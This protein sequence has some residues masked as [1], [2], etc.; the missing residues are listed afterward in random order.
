MDN[1]FSIKDKVIVITGAG[2]V[3]CSTM[4]VSLAQAGAK[5][6]VLDLIEA[7]A[8]KV[9]E[10]IKADK[11]IAIAIKCDVLDK[12]SLESAK[13][14]VISK[15]GNIDVLINGAGGNKKS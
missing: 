1:L 7:A 12:R 14:K 13:D 11:G 6:A 5:I 15:F 3:L 4:A 9:A 10:Q 8:N 2:G